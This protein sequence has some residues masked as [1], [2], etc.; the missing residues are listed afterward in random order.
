MSITKIVLALAKNTQKQ[1]NTRPVQLESDKTCFQN[2]N[3]ESVYMI[4]CRLQF[5]GYSD[6]Y[7]KKI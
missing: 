6:K 5:Q 7:H 3:S 4:E 1:F 2:N